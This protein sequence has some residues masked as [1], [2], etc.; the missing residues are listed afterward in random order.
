MKFN[1]DSLLF[2]SK[3]AMRLPNGSEPAG[4]IKIVPAGAR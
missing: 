2:V 1:V 4:L 3:A